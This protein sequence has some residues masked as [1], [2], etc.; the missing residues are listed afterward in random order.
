MTSVA[1]Q[2]LTLLNS[3]FVN[4]Q[5]R[6]FADR[7]A[8]E[9][10]DDPRRQVERAYRVALSR[11]PTEVESAET[12]AYLARE[13]EALAGRGE[14]EARREALARLGRVLFNLNEFV[15]PD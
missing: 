4:R 15:Y 5:A 3:G 10:G 12:A 2:A 11:P 9:A 7:L 6:H 14:T 8:R 13:A 1:T